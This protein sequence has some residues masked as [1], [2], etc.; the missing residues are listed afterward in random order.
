M[1]ETTSPLPPELWATVP[2][3]VRAPLLQEWATLRQENAA[4][5]AENVVLQQR[6]R[7][8]EA[9]LGRNSSNSSCPPSSDPP[10][11]PAKRQPQFSGRRRGGQRGG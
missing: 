10:Q 3:P 9:Q 11:A 6:V 1:M 5:R 7:E 2:A 4:L 8:L